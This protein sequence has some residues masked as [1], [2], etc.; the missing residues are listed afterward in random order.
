MGGEV[1]DR[2]VTPRPWRPHTPLSDEQSGG[3]P[4]LDHGLRELC[5]GE[6]RLEPSVL[7]RQLLEAFGLGGL[8]HPADY[9]YIPR[10][11]AAS[12]DSVAVETSRARQTHQPTLGGSAA[13]LSQAPQEPS[14]R[15]YRIG[16]YLTRTCRDQS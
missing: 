12:G 6:E 11:T 5:I 13:D 4:Q 15:R 3:T 8:W 1:L 16:A 9:V 10:T 7:L 2:A 14:V